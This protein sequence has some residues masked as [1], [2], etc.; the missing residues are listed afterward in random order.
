MLYFQS[1]RNIEDLIGRAKEVIPESAWSHTPIV[2]KATAG[3][4]LLPG[5]QAETLLTQ[6]RNVLSQ[7]GFLVD[8]EAVSIMDGVDEGLFSWFTVNFLLG[9]IFVLFFCG[10]VYGGVFYFL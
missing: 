4:R 5:E 6:A 3:L 2:M 9:G 8:N 1:G 7:S 10:E